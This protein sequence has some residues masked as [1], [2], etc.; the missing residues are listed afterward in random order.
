MSNFL[1]IATVTATLGDMLQSAIQADVPAAIV[2]KV[3]PDMQSAG[4]Q[5]PTV[6]IYL[7]QAT[8][9][10][11]LPFGLSGGTIPGRP[12]AALDLH[13][14]LSFSGDESKYEPQLL[15][16]SVIRILLDSPVLSKQAINEAALEP[17]FNDPS[18]P[19][20]LGAQVEPIRITPAAL[21]MD[22]MSKIWA[23][24]QIPYT[25]SVAYQASVVFIDG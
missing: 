12:R 7:Y 16:G 9:N 19:S 15:L 20:D 8:P 1:A 22:E 3:R 11:T 24:F 13:Y 21:S 6:N 25:L 2:T 23:L 5:T 18:H 10:S 17:P 4:V 14:L